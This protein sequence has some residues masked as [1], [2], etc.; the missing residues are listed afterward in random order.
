MAGAPPNVA[1]DE[2][3]ST[4]GQAGREARFD[5]A[6]LVGLALLSIALP[7]LVAWSGGALG[8]PRNDDFSYEGILFHWVR[9]GS[10]RFDNWPAMTLVGQL[11]IARPVVELLGARVTAFRF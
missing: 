8:I 9:T 1:L 4:V 5:C 11:A 6:V 3:V 2:R 10:L 7:L